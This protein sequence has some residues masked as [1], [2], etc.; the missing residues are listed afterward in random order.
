[1]VQILLALKI[2]W[3]LILII[4][5][6]YHRTNVISS[7]H[8]P[9]KQLWKLQA[10]NKI[11]AFLW[12]AFKDLLPTKMNF[13]RHKEISNLTCD[14][15]GEEQKYADH[16][17]W[18]CPVIGKTWHRSCLSETYL[19]LLNLLFFDV[20][21]HII[22]H[23]WLDHTTLGDFLYYWLSLNYGIIEMR[24]I[25]FPPDALV[26]KAAVFVIQFLE[27]NDRNSIGL[28]NFVS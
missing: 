17:L 18:S 11:Q 26:W 16:A 19:K 28:H 22:D 20:T 15:C 5:N 27:F 3:Y 13:L 21:V 10:P 2:N 6:N 12:K 1:M 23:L 7:T 25:L 8:N 14:N 4:K 9:R 24:S